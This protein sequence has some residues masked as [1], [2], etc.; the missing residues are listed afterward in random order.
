MATA[1]A[2]SNLATFVKDTLDKS[3]PRHRK[4]GGYMRHRVERRAANHHHIPSDEESCRDHHHHPFL[5]LIAIAIYLYLDL[6]DWQY[7]K[8]I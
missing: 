2:T 8:D 5:H 7:C 6:R 4:Q 3:T 1:L